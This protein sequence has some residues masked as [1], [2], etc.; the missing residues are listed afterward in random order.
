MQGK[1]V[2]LCVVKVDFCVFLCCFVVPRISSPLT[3]SLLGLRTQ[4]GKV[5][6]RTELRC[7][8]GLKYTDAIYFLHH[9]DEVCQMTVDRSVPVNHEPD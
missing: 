8:K 9:F 5:K 6:S 7:S 4:T 2:T 3:P 1:K